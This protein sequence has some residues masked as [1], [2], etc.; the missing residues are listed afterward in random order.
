M[1]SFGM[2]TLV[3]LPRLEDCAALCRE[4]GLDFIEVNTSFPQYQPDGLDADD[5]AALASKYGLYYTVHMDESFDPCHVNPRVR[6]AYLDTA[7]ETIDLALRLGI[8][9]LNMHL[10]RGV[11]VTLP[12]RKT[13]VYAENEAFYLEKLREFRDL[14]EKRIGDGK[15]RICIENTDGYDLPFLLHG[16][17][18]LLQSPVFALTL[19]IGHDNAI[20]GI[21][22]P[23]IL[24]R[25]DRLMHMHMH[26]GAGKKVHLALGDGSMDIPAYLRLAK[27]HGCRVV[28][29]TKTVE[30]LKSSVEYL[31]DTVAER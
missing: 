18:T 23:V 10:L 5:M 24:A 11:F 6:Q 4:L 31:R 21:D 28:L 14:A 12:D 25:G 29:E 15:L 30:A 26:D 19:D 9:T 16:V 20:G 3:E 7:M 2:P 27:E 17:D 13:Y 22:K 1:I 8:P